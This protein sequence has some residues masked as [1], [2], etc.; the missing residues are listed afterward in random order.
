M[1]RFVLNF[2]LRIFIFI[3]NKYLFFLSS[4]ISFLRKCLVK[5]VKK[6]K[7]FVLKKFEYEQF[8]IFS[9]RGKVEDLFFPSIY[10]LTDGGTI[11]KSFKNIDL[12]QFY[13][14]SF[15]LNSDFIRFG[16]KNVFCE[17]LSR[18]ENEFMLLGDADFLELDND[19]CALKS[20]ESSLNF[21]IVFHF[22]G[23]FFKVW[24]H[25]LVQYFP[26]LDFIKEIP[27]YEKVVIVLPI[28]LDLHIVHLIKQFLI[29]FK[30]VSIFYVDLNIEIKAKIMYYVS[31]DSWI[32]DVGKISSLFH[33][34][35]SDH[36]ASFVLDQASQYL[37]SKINRLKQ[38]LFI[39]RRG[40]RNI[41]N[42]SEVL[43]FFE[44]N[45][46]IEIF[47]H[48]LSFLEKVELF[49]SAE[50]IVGPL[51]SGFANIIFCNKSANVLVLSNSSRH[52]DLYLTKFSKRL[53]LNFLIFLGTEVQ[54]GYYDSDY[55]IDVSA[56]NKCFLE[57]KLNF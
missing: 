38:K 44:K 54:S 5:T 6:E 30:N 34:Q 55:Y 8:I 52:D 41:S 33:I 39:G 26:K 23:C 45:G 22:T 42:Y 43:C 51:S 50:Y 53:D 46:F 37:P 49:F 40:K 4:I 10:G 19:I 11:R 32:G 24:T 9:R 48:E 56:L 17:K 31:L 3:L 21:D 1:I 47:P 15:M 28:N 12:F 2:L 27:S 16:N 20:S 14:V 29:N 36:S 35:V 13:N 25:F 18:I 57:H 7:Y